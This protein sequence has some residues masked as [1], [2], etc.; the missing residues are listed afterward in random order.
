MV[1]ATNNCWWGGAGLPGP[2]RRYRRTTDR[3]DRSTTRGVHDLT[4]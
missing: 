2:A 3:S 4:A 1:A